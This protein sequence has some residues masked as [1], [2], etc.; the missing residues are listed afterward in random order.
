MRGAGRS[1]TI[2]R[3]AALLLL[4]G[5]AIGAGGCGSGTTATPAALRLAREDL[6]AVCRALSGAEPS[7]GRE[8]S[9]TKAAWPLVV[10]GLPADTAAISRPAIQ[11][12]AERAAE[13]SVPALFEE[14]QAASLTGPGSGLASLFRGYSSLAT[15][16]WQLI[17]AAIEEIEHG[18]PAAT[19]FARAN[20]ALYIESVYDAHFDL[21]QI[22]RQL[23]AGYRKLGGAA[24][25]GAS[26]TQAQ[27]DGLAQ[28]YSEAA[29]R[30]HPHTG[31]HLGS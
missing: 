17:G 25:F 26:L 20:V 2:G 8:V 15:R 13:L 23:L 1:R 27:V 7:V 29:D 5:V 4:S 16:G 24:A 10:N 21:A 12:A 6:A 9:A 19:R 22:G 30:L 11:A 3:F 31:V 14:H 28:T 18:S